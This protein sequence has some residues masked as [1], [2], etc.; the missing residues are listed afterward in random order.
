MAESTINVEQL[1]AAI[2]PSPA[3]PEEQKHAIAVLNRLL[4]KWSVPMREET[5]DV[6]NK[7]V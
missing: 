3:T 1:L 2:R 6:D 7:S 5:N 4:D